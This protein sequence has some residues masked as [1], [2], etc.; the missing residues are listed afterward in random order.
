MREIPLEA[1]PNQQLS[2]TIGSDRWTLRIKDAHGC[3][4]CDVTRNEVPMLL[5]QRIVAG[6]PLIPYEY[7]QGFGNFL[8]LVDGEDLADWRK[9]GVTQGLVYVGSGEM[10]A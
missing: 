10:L 8:L 7:L 6:T 4:V 2:V 9:F 5:A 1:V 3:I